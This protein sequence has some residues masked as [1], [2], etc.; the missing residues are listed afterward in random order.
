[1]T[2]RR[3]L[4]L[5]PHLIP[6]P[7]EELGADHMLPFG[8]GHHV[9]E[10]QVVP[11]CEG[12]TVQSGPS[13]LYVRD[14][15]DHRGVPVPPCVQLD[16]A[17]A[18]LGAPRGAPAATPHAADLRQD[19]RVPLELEPLVSAI[20][21]GSVAVPA[22]ESGQVL[23]VP[24][25]IP[26]APPHGVEDPA[27]DIAKACAVYRTL[28]PQVAVGDPLD[29]RIHLEHGFLTDPFYRVRLAVSEQTVVQRAAVLQG[30]QHPLLR[31]GV[32][33]D[34]VD[35]RRNPVALLAFHDCSTVIDVYKPNRGRSPNMFPS[36]II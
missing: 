23:Q 26:S 22:L 4:A 33:V 30:R 17:H 6:R 31:R 16:C 11:D 29:L 9:P 10:P 25:T 34:A 2:A 7:S 13:S 12:W 19:D 20:G 36:S 35:R 5:S 21:E 28:H 32:R 24:V 1:M 18:G 8:A 3:R 14:P 27:P 15:V